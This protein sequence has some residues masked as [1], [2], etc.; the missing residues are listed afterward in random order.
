MKNVFQAYKS[1]HRYYLRRGFIITTVHVDGE[2][3]PL[4]E[5]IEGMPGGPSMNL[6]RVNEHVPEIERGLRVVKERSRDLRHSLPY[7]RIPLI[8]TIRGILVIS[9]MLNQF[10]TKNRISKTFSH[11]TILNGE[12]LD[13]KNHLQIQFG[14]YYQV[15]ENHVAGSTCADSCR[16]GIYSEYSCLALGLNVF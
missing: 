14:Q 6:T 4:K 1:L 12:I 15:H 9:L 8:M 3:F 7:N 10:P 13:Y 5:L 11:K 2:N 16:L